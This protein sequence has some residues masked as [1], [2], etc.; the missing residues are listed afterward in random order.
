MA[1]VLM[2]I[3]EPVARPSRYNPNL[4]PAVEKVILKA[5][6]KDPEERFPTVAAMNQAYQGAVKGSPQTEAEWL[7]LR[8]PSEV[9]VAK[10]V[11]RTQVPDEGRSRRSPVVWVL[12]GLAL[13]LAVGGVVGA[14]ALSSLGAAAEPS[15]APTLAASPTAVS[16]I[17]AEASPTPVATATP[18]ISAGCP[19]VSL[20]G[21]KRDG[22][23]VSWAIY[24]GQP[25]DPIRL[26][27]FQF[28][29]PID[30]SLVDVRLG[31]PAP[32]G[33]LDAAGLVP[34]SGGDG[35][36]EVDAL[37]Q[38]RVR[39]EEDHDP[40]RRIG[41]RQILIGQARHRVGEGPRPTGQFYGERVGPPLAPA[42][43]RVL[44]WADEETHKGKYQQEDRKAGGVGRAG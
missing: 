36:G 24:N 7:H 3:Q 38:R 5:M 12:A 34:G 1:T 2:H 37:S 30:N 35:F 44:Q 40:M 23:E 13:A 43:V 27:S 39:S 20:L 42:R 26:S 29:V 25:D 10:Q 28:T 15:A 32:S 14:T 41:I 8:G 17:V 6:A 22:S 21:F 4:S 16:L 19:Q 31:G 9:A 11:V 33:R 18:S